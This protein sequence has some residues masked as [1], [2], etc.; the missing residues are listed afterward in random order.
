MSPG[1]APLVKPGGVLTCV[2]KPDVSPCPPP[3]N[4]RWKNNPGASPPGLFVSSAQPVD[5]P[6][7]EACRAESCDPSPA[8][9]NISLDLWPDGVLPPARIAYTRCS[10]PIS[11]ARRQVPGLDMGAP[12]LSA[13]GIGL[14]SSRWLAADVRA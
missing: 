6:G 13:W 3:P 4:V 1:Y 8:S 12:N 7:G 9:L 11:V 2:L 10:R 14:P 5:A